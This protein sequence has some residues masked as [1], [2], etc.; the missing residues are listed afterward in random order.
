MNKRERV[1]AALSGEKTDRVP[2]GFWMHF[3][4]EAYYGTTAVETHIKYFNESRTDICKIMNECTYPCDHNIQS[5]RDWKQVKIYDHTAAFIQCQ[6]D[7]IKR[8]VSHCKDAPTVATI[9]G[10]VASASHTLLGIPKYDSI[11]RFA[12][13]YH[14]RTSPIMVW[15]AYKKIA[16]TLCTIAKESIKAGAEGIY[17]AALG[18]EEDGFTDEEHAKYIAPLDQ[19]VIQAAYDAGAKFVIL[20]MCKPR[21]RLERFIDYPCDIVNWGIEESQISLTE[22]KKLFHNKVLLGGLNNQHGPLIDGGY[23]QLEKEIH[24][25]ITMTGGKRFILGS[26][27]TLPG[28]LSYEKIAMTVRAC[29]SYNLS[30]RD[31]VSA[32]R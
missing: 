23:D 32:K 25:I 18:G 26:D 6:T 3:K 15:D 2:V 21:V 27:C 29:E 30:R 14:L 11:G 19:L 12:Q 8:V 17:Y 28:E 24:K 20:H 10:V 31:L 5:A 22:G 4:P 1:F 7:V 9:H 16:D 13:L